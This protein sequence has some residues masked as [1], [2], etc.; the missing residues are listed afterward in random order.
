MLKMDNRCLT[1]AELYS[2][3]SQ[4]LLRLENIRCSIE[5]FIMNINH[6]PSLQVLT[7][8]FIHKNLVN[9]R[10][11]KTKNNSIFK[12]VNYDDQNVKI[13]QLPLPNGIKRTLLELNAK[14]QVHKRTIIM[15]PYVKPIILRYQIKKQSPLYVML[16]QCPLLSEQC[17]D[18][19]FEMN[20]LSNL[21]TLLLPNLPYSDS[22]YKIIRNNCHLI[23]IKYL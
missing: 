16:E 15:N 8:N 6:A 17:F 20:E 1:C 21:L 9:T 13:S 23:N 22:L 11:I 7:L 14:C 10:L 5:N 4:H 12:I 18:K 19:I 3:S 2:R